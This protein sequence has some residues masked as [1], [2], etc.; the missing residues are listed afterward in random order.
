MIGWREWKTTKRWSGLMKEN[1]TC[2]YWHDCAT[3]QQKI[4]AWCCGTKTDLRH[5]QGEGILF[6]H[7]ASEAAQL[8]KGLLVSSICG[9]SS[10]LPL[11]KKCAWVKDKGWRPYY[12]VTAPLPRLDQR[13]LGNFT[14]RRFGCNNPSLFQRSVFMCSIQLQRQNIHV[15]GNPPTIFSLP[16]VTGWTSRFDEVYKVLSENE[17]GALNSFVPEYFHFKGCRAHS[18]CSLQFWLTLVIG[19]MPY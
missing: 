1:H 17:F 10:T 13:T 15:I 7:L 3:T 6:K 12:D 4:L 9:N 8:L 11:S 14:W 19:I 5:L 16:T 2:H 18:N